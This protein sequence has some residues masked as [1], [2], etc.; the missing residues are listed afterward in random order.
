MNKGK[1]WELPECRRLE[2]EHEGK[3]NSDLRGRIGPTVFEVH[4]D[5]WF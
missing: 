4:D 2:E 1:K 5:S 3:W